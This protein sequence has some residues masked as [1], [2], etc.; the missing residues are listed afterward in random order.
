MYIDNLRRPRDAVRRKRPEI[1]RANR[2]FLLH[3][4]APAHRSCLATRFL[5]KNNVTTLEHPPYSPDLAPADFYLIPRLKSAL[6]WRRSCDAT[7]MITNAKE[8]LKMLLQNGLQ[9]F[10]NNFSVAGRGV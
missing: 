6:E 10:F 7:D 2:W 9:E 4:N 5:A 8:K 1:W 3:D